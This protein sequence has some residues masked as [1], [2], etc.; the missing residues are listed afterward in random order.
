[1]GHLQNL[2][3]EYRDLLGRLDAGQ[4]GM[5]EPEDPSARAGWQE[6]LEILFSP[7]EAALAARLPLVPASIETIAARVG[8][9]CDDLRPRL[10][11]MAEKGIVMDLLHPET[12]SPRYLLSPPMAGFFEF[13]LMRATPLIPKKRMAEALDAYAHGDATFAREVF[14]SETVIGRA[15]AHETALP[16]DLPDVLDWERATE[17]LDDARS[18]A[19][20]LCYC[21]HKNEHLGK[22]C[23]APA[24]NCMS[25]NAGADFVIR[26]GFGRPAERSEAMEILAAAR[27]SGLVQI[28]DNVRRQ[29]AYICNCCGCC[30]A[31]LT[32][33][34]EF[35]LPGVKPSGFQPVVD[36]ASCKG[37]SRCSR[38]C[39]ITAVSMIAE[40]SAAKRKNEMVP[41]IDLARCIG[42][43]VCVDACKNDAM[44][45][46]RRPEQA[47]I[48]EN[49]MERSIRMALERGRLPHLLFDAGASRGSRF[50][51][52]LMKVLC[53]LP[54]VQKVVA[55]E[56]VRSRFVRYALGSSSRP[57][58][59]T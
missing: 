32:A 44:R 22:A 58:Q 57:G 53:S 1:M 48:P 34:N 35:G 37:C 59:A 16:E 29:P 9:P 36:F 47:Y 33:I 17:L 42:C 11:R 23:D 45:M 15:L 3:T 24:D 8:I 20:T 31:Q 56:Q 25:L 30:C 46:E 41:R 49:S 13:S 27:E 7:E 10:E 28:A 2:K 50:L 39:P 5:P 43:G 21:R 38:A 40:R 18:I 12:G 6:I 54:P 4:V 14:G 52:G 55:S 51:N 19:V 26:R